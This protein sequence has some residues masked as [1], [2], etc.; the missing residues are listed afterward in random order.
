[1]WSLGSSQQRRIQPYHC[2]TATSSRG[3][4]TCLQKCTCIKQQVFHTAF[5][6]SF[7]AFSLLLSSLC[8]TDG[9][10]GVQDTVKSSNFDTGSKFC[11][12]SSV[13]LW[14]SAKS[15]L[16]DI[17]NLKTLSPLNLYSLLILL[18]AT[19]ELFGIFQRSVLGY[20]L[21]RN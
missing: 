7:V 13:F 5:L 19:N 9:T 17:K 12:P 14:L 21:W 6:Y 3:M 16:K 11:H 10:V 18:Y 20:F 15:I 4:S 2:F 1:M 8:L